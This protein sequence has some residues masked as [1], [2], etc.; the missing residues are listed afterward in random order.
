M[1]RVGNQRLTL[2]VP[3]DAIKGTVLS[4][5]YDPQLDGKLNL[6]LDI[7][8]V[9]SACVTIVLLALHFEFDGRRLSCRGWK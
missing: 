7:V 8:N 2:L 6:T 9:F 4:W 5:G 1:R 3:G